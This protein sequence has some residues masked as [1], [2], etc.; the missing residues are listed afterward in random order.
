MNAGWIKVHRSITDH[1]VW[2]CEF[3]YGQAWIDLL[4]HACFKPNK[5]M[6]KK[7]LVSLSVGQQARSEVTLAKQWK[8]SR[9]KVRR[10]LK[11]LENDGMIVIKTTHLTSIITICNYT[12]FQHDETASGTGN[13]TASDT[14]GGQQ[15]EHNKEGKKE[16]EGKQGKEINS[17]QAHMVFKHW[18]NIMNKPNSKLTTGRLSKIVARL[19]V[20]SFDDVCMAIENCSKSKFH[21]GNNDQNKQYNDIELICRNGEKLET[22]RDMPVMPDQLQDFSAKQQRSIIASQEFLNDQ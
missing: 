20:Y 14:T 15:A 16:K 18:Q 10:F 2:D 13:E 11:H 6:I 8:W 12:S 7:Q 3:S 5:F 22:F 1:W 9:N 19:K 4:S 17:E 21:M